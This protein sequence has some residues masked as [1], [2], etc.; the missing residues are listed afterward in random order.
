MEKIRIH[1]IFHGTVQGVGFRYKA[2]YSAKNRGVTGRGRYGVCGRGRAGCADHRGDGSRGLRRGYCGGHT[3]AGR[4]F[5]GKYR[6]DRVREYPDRGR[7]RV[8]DPLTALALSGVNPC[9]FHKGAQSRHGFIKF[10]KF[11]FTERGKSDIIRC[12][13]FVGDSR[14]GRNQSQEETK[15]G[16]DDDTEDPCKAR[17]S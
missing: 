13:S 16:Y 17:R 14:T 9:T 3:G 6:A 7:L 2:C 5:L 11:P 10:V 12:K 4:A 1:Y 8:R 15:H